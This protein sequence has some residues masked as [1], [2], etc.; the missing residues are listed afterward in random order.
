MSFPPETLWSTQLEYMYV[1]VNEV[2]V[3]QLSSVLFLLL[4]L[5]IEISFC[6]FVFAVMADVS[7]TAYELEPSA[8]EPAPPQLSLTAHPLPPPPPPPP[9]RP[10]RFTKKG[11][12][13]PPPSP[14]PKASGS[15]SSTT[16][17]P[18]SGSA[19]VVTP[20]R[21]EWWKRL[22]NALKVLRGFSS[23]DPDLR[24]EALASPKRSPDV[25]EPH[26]IIRSD[27]DLAKQWKMRYSEDN[28][29]MASFQI[30]S[31]VTM[32]LSMPILVH[33][34][35]YNRALPHTLL[36]LCLLNSAYIQS[37]CSGCGIR[38]S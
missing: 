11:Q 2:L 18:A 36:F 32:I 23:S 21:F 3:H 33:F 24:Q 31:L 1:K 30:S 35:M 16:F 5:V 27:E 34:V 19:S 10:R 15:S 13:T 20:G 26:A 12:L 14:V 6:T 38:S 37:A 8:D 22:K 4:A 9:P 29:K 7:S 17:A 25:L 28:V